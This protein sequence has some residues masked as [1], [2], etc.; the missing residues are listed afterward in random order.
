MNGNG[1]RHNAQAALIGLL[2]GAFGGLVGLGGGVVMIPLLVHTFRLSQVRAHGT[3]LAA[4]VVSGIAGAATYARFGSADLWGA[5]LLAAPAMATANLGAR[6][7]H[8]L[9]EWK[10]KRA[11]GAFLLFTT[12]L[13][14]ARPYLNAL[15]VSGAGGAV[16]T[17]GAG[18]AVLLAT[19]IF[20]GFLSGMMGVGGGSIMV[21]AMVVFLGVGQHLAQG[22]SLLA[23]VP[24][25]TVGAWTHFRLGNVAVSILPG[26]LAGIFLGSSLGAW[27]AHLL[28]DAALRAVFAVVQTWL[29]LRYLRTP[30]PAGKSGTA[31]TP[32]P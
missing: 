9:P 7:A 4:V 20:T 23:M 14:L 32:Q 6:F 2:A 28:P 26:L 8:A 18:I 22:T 24:T 12:A 5:L 15:A 17:S 11:F 10:L 31:K 16:G 30:A 1:T 13:L 27:I 21:P 25:G 3:S 29:G 19:G